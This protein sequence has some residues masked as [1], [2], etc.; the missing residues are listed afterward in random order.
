MSVTEQPSGAETADD[1]TVIYIEHAKIIYQLMLS[2]VRNRADAEELTAEVFSRALVSLRLTASR[3][4]IRGYLTATARTVLA[5]HW[6]R[7]SIG[8][9]TTLRDDLVDPGT[10]VSP[11]DDQRAWTI[12]AALPDRYRRILELRFL[13]AYTLKETAD[14]MGITIGNAKVLQ[15]RALAHAARFG[16]RSVGTAPGT[17]TSALASFRR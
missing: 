7:V 17:P 1:W 10:A 14:E 16:S 12:L 13:R 5:A 9:T 4:E 3:R 11:V 8:P 6:K 2:R 15:H